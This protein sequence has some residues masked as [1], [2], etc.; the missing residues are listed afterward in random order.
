MELAALPFL[1]L[2]DSYAKTAFSIM[3]PRQAWKRLG[4]EAGSPARAAHCT[5]L[6]AGGATVSHPNIFCQT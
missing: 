2:I 1:T 5:P 6:H 4:A 3:L